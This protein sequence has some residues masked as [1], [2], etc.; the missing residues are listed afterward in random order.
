M[1][2]ENFHKALNLFS[3]ILAREERIPRVHLGDNAAKAPNVDRKPIRQTENDLP[4]KVSQTKL[5]LSTSDQHSSYLWG[6]VKT[7]LYVCVHALLVETRASEIDEFDR[8]LIGVHEQD[9]FWFG[10]Q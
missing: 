1:L 5:L 9:V 7:A 6:T 4:G 2:T 3:F 10:R 8:G